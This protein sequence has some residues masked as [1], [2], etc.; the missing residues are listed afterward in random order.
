MNYNV[1]PLLQQID[2]STLTPPLPPTSDNIALSYEAAIPLGK[3]NMEQLTTWL[4]MLLLQLK[5]VYPTFKDRAMDG[6]EEIILQA[7]SDMSKKTMEKE[8]MT[9]KTKQQQG[10]IFGGSTISNRSRY[11]NTQMKDKTVDQHVGRYIM[12][13]NLNHIFKAYLQPHDTSQS[14]SANANATALLSEFTVEE[15]STVIEHLKTVIEERS[16]ADTLY[17]LQLEE[18]YKQQHRLLVENSTAVSSRKRMVEDLNGAESSNKKLKSNDYPVVSLP[19]CNTVENAHPP[20]NEVMFA[21]DVN[22]E[23]L[24]GGTITTIVSTA[25][26][27]VVKNEIIP[28]VKKESALTAQQPAV[29]QEPT[30]SVAAVNSE[31]KPVVRRPRV[32]IK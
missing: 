32:V 28:A 5:G 8:H 29:K 21:D 4:R 3:F 11:Y 30:A 22:L 18:Y 17:R 19:F 20:E 15:V 25:P 12:A 10:G 24:F 26:P 23:D 14:S 6:F 2:T 1:K 13:M 16:R 9:S 27:V 31:V 7:V